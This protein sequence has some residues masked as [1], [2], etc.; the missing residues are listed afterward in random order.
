MPALLGQIEARIPSLGQCV[1]CDGHSAFECNDLKLIIILCFVA[2]VQISDV[3][4]SVKGEIL[5]D[6]AILEKKTLLQKVQE[7]Y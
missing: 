5:R 1:C 2:L 6:Q 7:I 4:T 3:I